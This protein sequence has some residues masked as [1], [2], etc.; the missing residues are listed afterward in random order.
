[1]ISPKKMSVTDE[2]LFNTDN[3]SAETVDQMLKFLNL[4]KDRLSM[5]ER[6][7]QAME[8]KGT[9]PKNIL[10]KELKSSL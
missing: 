7:R 1:M 9:K 5:D 3:V 8:D 4:P 10:I 2:Y 6:Y